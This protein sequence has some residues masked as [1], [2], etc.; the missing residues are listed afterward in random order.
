[1]ERETT[2]P[3][4]ALGMRWERTFLHPPLLAD[5]A[6]PSVLRR[7]RM[8][9]WSATACPAG[10]L[11]AWLT[12]RAVGRPV[13]A[14]E[15]L[16]ELLMLSVLCVLP[17]LRRGVSVSRLGVL[18]GAVLVSV[19]FIPIV[20]YQ[21]RALPATLLLTTFPA[22]TMVLVGGRS[23]LAMCGVVIG[24]LAA[25]GLL[26]DLRPDL[27]LPLPEA[28]QERWLF[29]VPCLLALMQ[30]TL[31]MLIESSRRRS[32]EELDASRDALAE[33]EM[34]F[35]AVFEAAPL[36][37]GVFDVDGEV[38]EVNPHGRQM[39][40]LRPGTRPD[41][42]SLV[43]CIHPED[44]E[45]A[46][47]CL[48]RALV[49]HDDPPLEV[50]WVR[51]GREL[52]WAEVTVKVVREPD[53]APRFVVGCA[54]FI[55]ERRA[56]DERIKALAFF[57]GVTGLATRRVFI[58]RLTRAIDVAEK[59][60]HPL[61]VLFLDLDGFKNVNDRHG[62]ELGD[63]VLSLVAERFASSI[64]LSD[65]MGRVPDEI[66]VSRYGGDEFTVMLAEVNGAKGA[67]VVARRIARSLDRPIEAQGASVQLGVSIGIALYPDDGTTAE[68]L[69]RNADAAMYRA[70]RESGS[71]FC[72]HEGDSVDHV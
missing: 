25:V 27:A 60:R 45:R 51:P 54:E 10:I 46:V 29:A 37:V 52:E 32:V 12:N 16:T 66:E 15:T 24:G 38:A 71:A 48:R 7:A 56:A 72:L 65:Q 41:E 23:A 68:E 40:G 58:D 39:L 59:R 1:M 31:V 57:D 6:D 43:S 42:G 8:L 61:A 35:R 67:E 70:K 3:L 22:I 17:L 55:T 53:G 26:A 47:L 63:E 69:L 62:H 13:A 20:A 49:G 2:A 30:T 11:L 64:R 44:A 33:S 28:V 36:G 4:R 34:R 21:G 14:V 9:L 18:F 5:G 50:R 19:A